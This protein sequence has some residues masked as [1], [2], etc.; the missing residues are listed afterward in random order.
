MAAHALAAGGGR[1]GALTLLVSP[2]RGPWL[3]RSHEWAVHD[4]AVD[5]ATV[6]FPPQSRVI[7][8]EGEM[9]ALRYMQAAGG[10]GL[11]ATPIVADDPALRREAVA[12]GLAAGAP[13]FLTREVA[14]I[15]DQYSFSGAGPLVRV[16]HAGR[17]R[18]RRPKSPKATLRRR[19]VAA[20]RLHPGTPCLGW[21][22]GGAGD[23]LLAA[24]RP[25]TQTFK[26]SLRVV[27]AV[28]A[29]LPLADGS[30]AVADRYPLRNV[31]P[32]PTWLPGETVGDVHEFYLPP[33]TGQQ[34]LLAI[35]YDADTLAEVGRIRIPLGE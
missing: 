20:A 5:M 12:A 32:S 4:Y 3:D 9:T 8:L 11:D 1:A 7:G 35:L 2:G 17:R 10:L 31:A 30:P 34:T 29:V 26:L 22:A 19:A 23:L 24:H 25:L 28:D 27:D 33:G 15:A 13:V 14:G 21:R 18:Q 6:A 16:G